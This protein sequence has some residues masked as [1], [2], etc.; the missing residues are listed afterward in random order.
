MDDKEKKEVEDARLA[1]EKYRNAHDQMYVDFKGRQDTDTQ[2]KIFGD[3]LKELEI[4]GFIAEKEQPPHEAISVFFDKSLLY[5]V[6]E[7]GYEDYDDYKTNSS[8]ND[9]ETLQTM[10][11]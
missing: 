1:V 8:L 11:K 10:W 2:I 4:Y 7:L 3:L 5:N 9:K 6:Q